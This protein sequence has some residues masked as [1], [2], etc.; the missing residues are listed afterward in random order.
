M[1]DICNKENCSFFDLDSI[2]PDNKWGYKNSTNL[3][4]EKKEIDFMHF[5][6]DGHKK[7]SKKLKKIL[8]NLIN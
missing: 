2:I 6:Y 8:N 1:K 3:Q 4:R 7:I 5:T